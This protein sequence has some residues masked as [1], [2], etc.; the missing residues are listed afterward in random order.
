[1]ADITTIDERYDDELRRQ[2]A[3]LKETHDTGKRMYEDV[4]SGGAAAYETLKNEARIDKALT[5]LAGG[6]ASTSLTYRQRG[7]MALRN[8]LGDTGRQHERFAGNV[9][10]ALANL[11]MQH[12]ADEAGLSAVNAARRNAETVSQGRFDAELGLQKQ[13]L[14]RQQA[15]SVFDQMMKLYS[16]GL[17][18][19]TQ[20]KALTGVEVKSLPKRRRRK[21]DTGAQT[22]ASQAII[23]TNKAAVEQAK[24]A[25]GGSFAK[26]SLAQGGGGYTGISRDFAGSGDGTKTSRFDAA[27]SANERYISTLK[28]DEERYINDF[29]MANYDAAL[30][31]FT[32]RK[33]YAPFEGKGIYNA[34]SGY[35]SLMTGDAS[36]QRAKLA[37]N[38]D[39]F[40]SR[41]GEGLY[42]LYINH[43]TGLSGAGQYYSTEDRAAIYG[44]FNEILAAAANGADNQS[45]IEAYQK[46][47]DNAEEN[48]YGQ[49]PDAVSW[50][51]VQAAFPEIAAQ[52]DYE[53]SEED[54]KRAAMGIQPESF[55]KEELIKAFMA[56]RLDS[57]GDP[58]KMLLQKNQI[59]LIQPYL[60]QLDETSLLAV[61]AYI[62]STSDSGSAAERNPLYREFAQAGKEL[63]ERL[64]SQNDE[65][66]IAAADAVGDEYDS[67]ATAELK[68]K[69]NEQGRDWDELPASLRARHAREKI[70]NYYNGDP[71]A[72]YLTFDFDAAQREIDDL[73]N[74][75]DSKRP[76]EEKLLEETYIQN[77]ELSRLN[78]EKLEQYRADEIVPLQERKASK[79]AEIDM[80][81]QYKL[82]NSPDFLIYSQE[83]A[84]I[85]P[86]SV[87]DVMFGGDENNV[88]AYA[89]YLNTDM[90]MDELLDP[91]F[92]ERGG[93]PDDLEKWIEAQRSIYEKYTYM[94][95]D[96][97]DVYNY[98]LAKEGD[99]SANEYLGQI[100]ETLNYRQGTAAAATLKDRPAT[101]VL[102]SIPAG[103]D[104]FGSGIR[105][106]FSSD[107]LP[108]TATQFASSA[109]YE[110]LG[111]GSGKKNFGQLVYDL[112][113]GIGYMAPTILLSAVTGGLG[114][115]AA[116]AS[117]VGAAAMGLSA[118]GNAY[119][120][121]LGEGYSKGQAETYSA[122][123]KAR[124][125]ICWA[126]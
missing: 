35:D 20:F 112:G 36:A 15:D 87:A 49:H 103:I 38:K 30:D 80:A 84:N 66:M 8:E 86:S 26:A 88:V 119:N 11:D 106:L 93:R 55:T 40:V 12:T 14:E 113:T 17:V 2:R 116:V 107:R 76:M 89:R 73:N 97:V 67:K 99:A 121:A 105:Q 125:N 3:R 62:Q 122:L 18:N 23:D 24:A 57:F 79:Q 19:K 39:D 61:W 41:F 53:D 37:A 91:Q 108:A 71:A 43:F 60:N 7:D 83:G 78:Q 95:D 85:A 29:G 52:F 22:A 96:E 42:E 77:F 114:A 46:A 47:F 110:D 98:L 74:Q 54:N 58:I 45:A 50:R 70:Q 124:F 28:D 118:K 68:K 126:A 6:P 1:M 16:K 81:K 34:T 102:Y 4:L 31:Y 72:Y 65:A 109:I 92:S 94:T 120:W 104:S 21:S 5:D 82:L 51:K 75:I 69:L 59:Q 27:D 10:H 25:A 111:G 123:P 117:G 32:Q 101:Q 100:E 90:V 115:P 9:A 63:F 56:D 48:L 13:Q 64:R 44:A 33:A